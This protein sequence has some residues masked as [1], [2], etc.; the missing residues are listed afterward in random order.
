MPELP[1]V[2]TIRRGLSD[3]IRGKKIADAKIF[4]PNLRIKFPEGF[5]DYLK[6]RTIK[7]IKRRS[8]YLLIENDG[9]KTLLCHL[10]MSGKVLVNDNIPDLQKHDHVLF[11]FE[12]NSSLIY[13]DARR[14]GLMTLVD[15][16]EIDSHPLLCH[17]GPEPLSNGFSG[18]V[19][20]QALQKKSSPIKNVIMDSRVVVGVGNIYACESLFRS[21]ISPLR[22]ANKIKRCEAD[23]LAANIIDVLKE[24][25][26]SGGSTL[27]DYVKSTGDMGY[28]QHKFDV[29]GREGDLCHNCASEIKR[30]KQ[31]GRSSFYC[32][33][34]QS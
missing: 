14:F 25:I 28:F 18:E 3:S 11:Q 5:C 33:S 15:N 17:L 26:E 9:D 7:N 20:Y 29:Y 31:Q 19:L 21:K 1:E 13:N 22:K 30:V 12:D 32:L 4:R 24:A 6:N 8:K 2:E 34:C 27:K 10:G 16:D 23:T